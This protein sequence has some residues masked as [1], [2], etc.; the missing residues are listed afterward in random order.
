MPHAPFVPLRIHSA[1]SVLEGALQSEDIARIAGETGVPALAVTDRN[2][3]FGAMEISAK[4]LKAGVQPIVGCLIGIERQLPTSPHGPSRAPVDWLPLLAATEIGYTNLLALVSQAHLRDQTSEAPSITF[5]ALASRAEGLIC[6]TGAQDGFAWRSLADGDE[7]GARAWLDRLKALFGDR[8]YVEIVRQD[9]PHEAAIEAFLLDWAEAA[10]VPLVATNPAFCATPDKVPV[11]DALL[12]LAD[13]EFIEQGERSRKP[14]PH[15]YWR[16][17]REMARLFDDLPEALANSI[18]VAQRCAVIAPERKPILPGFGDGQTSEADLLTRAAQAGLRRRLDMVA[19]ANEAPY[20]ERLTF[21]LDVIIRMGF[22]GYFLIVA[23]FIQWAKDHGIPVGPG[24]GSGAGSLVAW[25]LRITDLDPLRLGLLFERFLNPER[26]SMPDFDIDFCETRR[27]EVIRYVQEK[28]GHDHVAQIITFGRQKARAAV[29]SVGRVLK[30]PY[31][32]VDALSK[33]IPNNPA[34]PVTLAQAIEGEPRLREA[35]S[36]DEAVARLI[37]TAL[38][39]E[40]TIS[41]A[42]TH[43]AGVVIGDRPLQQ[44]VPLYRD[45]GSDMPVT[46]F[47]MKW[48]EAAGLV[49]FDFLGL[50][51]LSVLQRGVDLLAQR[52]IVLDLARVPWDDPAT[53]SLLQSGETLGVFQ[54]EG[55]GMRR[56]L[57]GMKPDKFEDIIALVALYR[58]GPMENIPTYNARKHKLEDVDYLHPWLEAV[59]G[60]TYGVI[61]YQEQVM[62]IAQILAGYSLGEADLLRR[63]MGKKIKAEMDAQAERFVSG[64]VAKGVDKAQAESIFRLVEKFAGYGFNKSHAAAY[65]LVA[66]HTA[67]LKANH[68]VEFFAATM[69]FDLGNTDKLAFIAYDMKRFEVPLLPPCIN[70]GAA[71]FSVEPQGNGWAVRYALAALKGVGLKAME[72]IVEE[73]QRGGR[74]RSLADFASRID[75]RSL[76]TRQLESLAAAGAFD[77]LEPSRAVVSAIGTPLIQ[78]ATRLTQEKASQQSSL[79]GDPGAAQAADLPLPKCDPWPKARVMEAER[80]A[81]GF[82]FSGHP[83]DSFLHV[84]RARQV[85]TSAEAL[86]RERPPEGRV[87][88]M[89]AGIAEKAEIRRFP[90][91]PEPFTNLLASDAM[92]QYRL[93]CF[94]ADVAEAAQR[95]A[96]TNAAILIQTELMWR[97]DDEQPRMTAR[98]IQPLEA[99]ADSVAATLEVTVCGPQALAPLASLLGQK[100]GGRGTVQLWLHNGATRRQVLLALPG[101][102]KVEPALAAALKAL[103]G[104]EDARIKA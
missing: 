49:K 7:A 43:A 2:N 31:G 62:Q 48:V 4:L 41:H 5:D 75:P 96:E 14:S 33:L 87:T 17:P 67:Y 83:L 91:R 37:D 60:E 50:K 6:L 61:I 9:W 28:Y 56:A 27:D 90:D 70:A 21:E 52:G 39:I 93:R 16:T 25:S 40:G 102:H 68:P 30:M 79:F 55:D 66:Y 54:L 57:A 1:Y 10:N 38:E 97:P 24:R 74:F 34:N 12:C 88:V 85:I 101:P 94:D 44:L 104:V 63:A 76:N 19:V 95:A 80:D 35:R 89:L 82:Y 73:R 26:V 3:L 71:D 81:F 47:D 84:L 15:V 58:P 11:H 92:G 20:V 29:K 13:K 8:L 86:L 18:V 36:Q 65:A 77:A 53:F 32:Q 46:Q 69:A 51:T 99:L 22:A 103:P 45:P 100:R 98:S 72:Q 64:A 42:S 23:D 59:L 78:L